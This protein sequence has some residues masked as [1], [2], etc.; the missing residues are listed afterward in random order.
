M[1]SRLMIVL[2]SLFAVFLLVSAVF[3]PLA[4]FPLGGRLA[5]L[6]IVLGVLRGIVRRLFRIGRR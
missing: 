3:T 6:L 4:M 1:W 5:V 2:I